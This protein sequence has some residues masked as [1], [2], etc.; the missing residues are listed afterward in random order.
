MGNSM[1]AQ[2]GVRGRADWAGGLPDWTLIG[3]GQ[4]RLFVIAATHMR[5]DKGEELIGSSPLTQVRLTEESPGY[6][7]FRGLT[8]RPS[9]GRWE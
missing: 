7:N 3:A 1:G 2:P 9:S 5:P 8:T 4:S 6:R